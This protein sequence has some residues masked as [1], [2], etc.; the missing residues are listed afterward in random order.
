MTTDL[1]P[2]EEAQALADLIIAAFP[3]L[4]VASGSDLTPLDR[5]DLA[6]VIVGWAETPDDGV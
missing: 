5:V 4:I 3:G 1:L 6:L 2:S